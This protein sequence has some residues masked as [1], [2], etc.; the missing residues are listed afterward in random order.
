[1][2]VTENEYINILPSQ[3]FMIM[4]IVIGVLVILFSSLFIV[5]DY[6]IIRKEIK[7]MNITHF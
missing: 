5:L 4:F 7:G 3:Y 1:M 6:L 2:N